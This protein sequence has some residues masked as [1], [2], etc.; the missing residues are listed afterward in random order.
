M[1]PMHRILF[2]IIL[3]ILLIQ[4]Q[5][6]Y[7]QQD[8]IED[9]ELLRESVERDRADKKEARRKKF[10]ATLPKNHNPK[11]ATLLALIPGAGQIY[12]RR[13]WKLPIVYGGLGALGYFMVSN[14]ID[15]NCYRT[16]YLHKV[17]LDST[18][19]YTCPT[20]PD[21]DER[22]LKI[23]RDNS[24]SS[25]EMFLLGFVFFYG[26]T[27][28]DA[29]VDAHLL[30]FDID[31]NLS[32]HIRPSVNYSLVSQTVVPSVSLMVSGR[33]KERILPVRF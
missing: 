15:Y 23:Y 9:P 14:Y 28:V 26:L 13:Y 11:T 32:L 17:D 16:A 5:E 33:V 20:L 31:D 21:A 22:T 27:I 30:H 4:N 2:A 3:F 1:Y 12:N 10:L 25:A 18:T 19:N 6:L 24:Q 8:S 7:A 29:F